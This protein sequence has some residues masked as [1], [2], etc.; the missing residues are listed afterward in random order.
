[1]TTLDK[2]NDAY[3]RE[4]IVLAARGTEKKWRL[5]QELLSPCYTTRLEDIIQIKS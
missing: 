2:I 5:K 4:K 1:M 3:G